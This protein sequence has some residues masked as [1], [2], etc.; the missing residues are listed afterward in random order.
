[1]V[2]KKKLKGMMAIEITPFTNDGKL[3]ET[4][5]K[6]LL[7][8]ILKSGITGMIAAGHISE[9]ALMPESELKKLWKITLDHINGKIPVGF[10]TLRDSVVA[11]TNLVKTA[12]DMGADF[13]MTPPGKGPL[14]IEQ[15]MKNYDYICSKTDIPLMLY[16][17]LFYVPLQAPVVSRLVDEHSN[18]C[19]AK[20]ERTLNDVHHLAEAG[21]LKKVDIL[22]GSEPAL[23]VH[24]KDG[25]AG[26]TLS[27][28]LV[29]PKMMNAVYKAAE[30]KDWA[31][32]W[33]AYEEVR[34]IIA[35]LYNPNYGGVVF[36]D[37]LYMMGIFDSV[38]YCNLR[39]PLT[40]EQKTSLRKVLQGA[41]VKLV[42]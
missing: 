33:V 17:S 14:T 1:M 24:L 4:S 30:E 41:G 36:K 5:Y 16:D 32:A 20:A 35:T 9:G 2:Q 34:P 25:A 28:P 19:Y 3:D 42:R 31:K 10:G 29:V 40:D 15:I 23:L 8:N 21:V 22:C 11:I 18:I 38:N 39:P 7:D 13:T 6:R 37:A 12:Q 27:V 26:M